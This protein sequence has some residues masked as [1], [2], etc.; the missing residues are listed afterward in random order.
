MHLQIC[1]VMCQREIEEMAICLKKTNELK[2]FRLLM[3]LYKRED[4]INLLRSNPIVQY[5][6]QLSAQISL[7]REKIRR[8][9][10]VATQSLPKARLSERAQLQ[11]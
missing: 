7:L 11:S 2:L 3:M 1:G 9:R 5:L 10:R 6:D 4:G 8:Y